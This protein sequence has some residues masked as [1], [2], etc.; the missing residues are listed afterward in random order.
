MHG[1]H[2]TLKM[3]IIS[4]EKNDVSRIKIKKSCDTIDFQNDDNEFE[5]IL[6]FIEMNAEFADELVNSMNKIIVEL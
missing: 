2:Y 6:S 3:N 1:F 4:A 5:S